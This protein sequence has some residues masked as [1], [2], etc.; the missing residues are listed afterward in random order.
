MN[1]NSWYWLYFLYTH[2]HT[3]GGTME[4]SP[5]QRQRQFWPANETLVS[6]SG[7]ARVVARTTLSLSGQATPFSPYYSSTIVMC[8]WIH[9]CRFLCGTLLIKMGQKNESI[10][11]VRNPWIVPWEC[12]MVSWERGSIVH[13]SRM[14]GDSL[15]TTH[16][17]RWYILALWQS[18]VLCCHQNVLCCFVH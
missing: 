7:T 9:A 1:T 10:V 4:P 2:T 18:Y 8:L 15:R 3:A 12:V 17:L 11:L 5:E 14:V 16:M 13:Y 6:W